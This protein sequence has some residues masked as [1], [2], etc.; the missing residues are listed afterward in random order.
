M[1]GARGGCEK[2]RS[3]F[4]I[5]SHT[6]LSANLLFVTLEHLFATSKNEHALQM[7]KTPGFS[8]SATHASKNLSYQ[9]FIKEMI[10]KIQSMSQEKVAATWFG[11]GAGASPSRR[12]CEVHLVCKS[13]FAN[14]LIVI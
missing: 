7:N 14:V 5:K 8:S 2:F 3:I 6:K 10:P 12:K 4:D 1:L 13:G 9:G 11:R